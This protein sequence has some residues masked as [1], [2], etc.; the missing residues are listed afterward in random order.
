MKVLH[1]FSNKRWTGPAEPALNLCVSLRQLGVE[2]DLAC[3]PGS[4]DRLNQIVEA[5][6]DKDVEPILDFNLLKH[7]NL[8]KNRQDRRTLAH[9]AAD[10]LRRPACLILGQRLPDAYDRRQVVAQGGLHAFVDRSIGLAEVRPPLRV[11]EDH[12]AAQRLEHPG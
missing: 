5:A 12:V 7:R 3:A 11:S 1:L 4:G 9:L 6:R 8:L 10:D 2:A